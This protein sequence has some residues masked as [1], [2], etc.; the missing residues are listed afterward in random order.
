MLGKFGNDIF[1][2]IPKVA[3]KGENKFNPLKMTW[4]FKP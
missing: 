3:P 1:V 2:S 4:D